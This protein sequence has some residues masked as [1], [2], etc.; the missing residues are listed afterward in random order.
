MPR[1]SRH[2]PAAPPA[3]LTALELRD[4]PERLV[5][6]AG[7]AAVREA[8]QHLARGGQVELAQAGQRAVAGRRDAREVLLAARAGLPVV[9]REGG[10]ALE[11]RRLAI[12][13][14]RV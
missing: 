5:G 9:A 2:G 7:L 13:D 1:L 14:R 8:V 4:L 3:V 6:V 12:H 10:P 11:Q